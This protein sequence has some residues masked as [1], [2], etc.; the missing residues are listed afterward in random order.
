MRKSAIKAK[1]I[2]H[3]S[4]AANEAEEARWWEENQEYIL[5]GFQTDKKKGNLLRSASAI[6][7]VERAPT[8]MISIRLPESDL[9]LA[10]TQAQKNGVAY[11]TWLKRII[12]R[13]LRKA[14]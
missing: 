9:E 5:K 10:R 14:G 13:G 3:W 7:A 11:Q 6:A 12:H 4:E 2:S 8:R 1:K